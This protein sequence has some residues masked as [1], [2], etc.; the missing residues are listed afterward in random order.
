MNQVYAGVGP[1]THGRLG[2]CHDTVGPK[3]GERPERQRPIIMLVLPAAALERWRQE[4]G[5]VVDA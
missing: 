4:H 3:S 2:E 1:D 5:E